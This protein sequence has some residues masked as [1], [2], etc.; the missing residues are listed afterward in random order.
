MAAVRPWLPHGGQE[1]RASGQPCAVCPAVP[2]ENRITRAP[3]A[4]ASRRVPVDSSQSSFGHAAADTR[5]RPPADSRSR[6]RAMLAG[7]HAPFRPYGLAECSSGSRSDHDVIQ[8]HLDVPAVLPQ[9]VLGPF[10][11]DQMNIAQIHRLE[12]AWIALEENPLVRRNTGEGVNL[13]STRAPHLNIIGMSHAQRLASTQMYGR[14]QYVLERDRRPRRPELDSLEQVRSSAADSL[15][16]NLSPVTPKMP[17]QR[18][19]IS[20][21]GSSSTVE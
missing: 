5:V 18:A 6:P 14:D 21:G 17:M 11:A 15:N 13:Q 9:Q 10:H 20:F 19:V 12:R 2:K 8:R 1:V 7:T 3:V 16:V 4:N